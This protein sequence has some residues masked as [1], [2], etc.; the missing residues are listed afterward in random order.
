MATIIYFKVAR[1]IS[2]A[3][4]PSDNCS[5]PAESTVTVNNTDDMP[6]E[7]L[8]VIAWNVMVVMKLMMIMISTAADLQ[9]AM[10]NQRQLHMIYN[11]N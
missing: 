10:K 4:L 8:G 1:E 2:L 7:C 3:S 5:A 6:S 11:L 9:S